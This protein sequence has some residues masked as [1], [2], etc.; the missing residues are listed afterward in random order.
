MKED[1]KS[2]SIDIINDIPQ[3]EDTDFAICRIQGLSCG[4]NSH[5]LILSE[6]VLKRDA[7]TCLGKFIV[8]KTKRDIFGT[9][10][11]MGH[12]DDEVII[13]YVPPNAEI[14][15]VENDSDNGTFFEVDA[16]VSKL[17]T[18]GAID[19]FKRDGVKSV[20]CEF[21]CAFSEEDENVIDSFNI[22]GIT[23]LGTDIRPSC[24]GA[25]AEI[26]QFSETRASEYYNSLWKE[27]KMAEKKTYKIDK[28]KDAMS[29]RDWGDVDKTALR[30]KILEAKNA[31]T[32]VKSVYLLV[33][34]GWKD[35]PSEKLKYP[36]MELVGDTFVYNRNALA[37]AKAYATQHDEQTVLDK[38]NKI[39]EKLDLDKEEDV[40]MANVE[41]T[42]V[43]IG[44]L[45]SK[46]WNILEEKRHWEYCIEGV[47]E[48]AGQK[49]VIL[50]DRESGFYRVD[51][52]LTEDGEIE[53]GEEA[54]K[55]EKTFLET[56]TVVKFEEPE[57]VEQ[58]KFAEPEDNG[59]EDKEEPAEEDKEELSCGGEKMEEPAPAPEDEEM[60]CGKEKMEEEPEEKQ[61]PQEE[62]LSSDAYVD[63]AA[64]EK[65]LEEQAQ[66]NKELAEKEDIIMKYEAELE[67]LRK[68]REETLE[69]SKVV[70][71]NNFLARFQGKINEEKYKKLEEESKEI[72]FEELDA[73]KN[74]ALASYAEEILS[75]SAENNEEI[76]RM[77]VPQETKK[78]GLW[79]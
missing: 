66:K 48:E 27:E 54:V 6:E 10:D 17:Y 60:A 79:D 68:F 67:E 43:N 51:L 29:E 40:K 73:W 62:K 26:I 49:F 12:E 31:S 44:D 32:L 5:G 47:Y 36:V 56:E 11:F 19:I 22:K 77:M 52:T 18:N 8:A 38:L 65:L 23:I 71:V 53:L 13:G 14:R 20:S 50:C 63:S 39:Y 42:A 78:N 28:S 34:D 74:K 37:S 45:W 15:F 41:F 55:V 64:Y 59:S 69:A 7:H 61:E 35:A 9:Q 24:T 30:N 4:Y 16:V 72:K 1:I 25:N 70:E 57:N 76:T 58:Y 75:F 46:I 21:V 3:D 2:F 33:E